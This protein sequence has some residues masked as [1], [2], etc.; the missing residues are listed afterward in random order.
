MWGHYR[1]DKWGERGRGAR[2]RRS[3]SMDFDIHWYTLSLYIPYH[4]Y[5]C[6]KIQTLM[7][8][9]KPVR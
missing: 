6:R 5:V 9:N 2:S 1:R 3:D 8:K 4:L 7:T